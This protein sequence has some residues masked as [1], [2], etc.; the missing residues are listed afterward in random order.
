MPQTSSGVPIKLY[1]NGDGTFNLGI[2]APVGTAGTS[3]GTGTTT[4]VGTQTVT[5]TVTTIPSGTQT[6]AV[7][8]SVSV[9]SLP[10]GTNTIGSVVVVPSGTQSIQGTVTEIPSGTQTVAGTVTI[11][12][13]GTQMVV[14]LPATKAIYSGGSFGWTV[15]ALCQDAIVIVGSPT[16]LV[17]VLSYQMYIYTSTATSGTYALIKRLTPNTGGTSITVSSTLPW[18]SA[19]PAPTAAVKVYTAVP[20]T[21]GTLAGT[22]Q[23]MAI[24]VPLKTDIA[25]NSAVPWMYDFS[26]GGL[27][28]GL[29][30]RGT[31]ESVAFT[32]LSAPPAGASIAAGFV[33]SEE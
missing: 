14:Q 11:V 16:K 7:T 12:P 15:P 31:N 32:L 5:G 6:S 19:N 27:S 9:T 8:G 33:W 23:S 22:I 3:T 10:T 26:L 28:S 20:A 13:S 21:F 30:L 2:Q 24:R 18:D 29:V 17:R 25:N 4:V 1:D